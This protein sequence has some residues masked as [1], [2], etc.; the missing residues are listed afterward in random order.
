MKWLPMN[1]APL[2]RDILLLVDD[3]AIQ[4]QMIPTDEKPLNFNIEGCPSH[5]CGCCGGEDPYPEG[6]QELPTKE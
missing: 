2:C 1:T 6:W 3:V 5:G 4:G